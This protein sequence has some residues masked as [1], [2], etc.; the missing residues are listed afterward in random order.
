MH[1]TSLPRTCL[2]FTNILFF[3]VAFVCCLAGVWCVL[4]ADMFR[5][6][7][8]GLT[9]S[10]YVPALTSLAGLRLWSAPL[11]SVVIA[12]AAL[13]MFTS[14]CGVIGAGCKVKCAVRTYVFLVTVASAAAF[15]LFF[16]TGV[17]G[18]YSG[19]PHTRAYLGST[20][21]THYGDGGDLLSVLWDHLMLRYECCG[22]SGHADF[23]QSKW[24]ETH[25]DELFPVQCCTLV[26][27]TTLTPLDPDCTKNAVEGAGNHISRGC[28]DALRAEIRSNRGSFILYASLASVSYFLLVSFSF[29]L[30]RGEP[31]LDS[32]NW[33]PVKPQPNQPQPPPA[34]AL[35]EIKVTVPRRPVADGAFF[36]DE[37]P[38]K[39]VRVVSAI[40][41]G[42]SYKLEPSVYR[43]NETWPYNVKA[44]IK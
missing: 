28:Y 4:N 1:T 39:I 15:W 23:A 31:L 44:Q 20:I 17:Y 8:Y 30:I 6:V 32:S 27:K 19:D 24:R 14:C 7:N 3:C 36:E 11:T 38:M 29:C 34:K 25:P 16:V 22:A 42:L 21:R 18:V 12:V 13:T 10:R 5:E 43:G 37:P 2:S 35:R 41:P 33:V 26:N 40:N 9:K